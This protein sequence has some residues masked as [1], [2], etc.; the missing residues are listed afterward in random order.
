MSITWIASGI[1]PLAYL[2]E[3]LDIYRT[4]LRRENYRAIVA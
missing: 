3:L 1:S 2:N 4:K